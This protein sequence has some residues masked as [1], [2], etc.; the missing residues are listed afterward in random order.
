MKPY[1]AQYIGRTVTAVEAVTDDDGHEWTV[2]SFDD[3]GKVYIPHEHPWVHVDA[4][5]V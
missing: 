5:L 3:G 4:L 1:L 2:F